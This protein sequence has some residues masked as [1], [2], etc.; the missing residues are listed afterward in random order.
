MRF[1]SL[2]PQWERRVED[3]VSKVVF[4]RLGPHLAIAHKSAVELLSATS[5]ATIATLPLKHT[6]ALS[7]SYDIRVLMVGHRDGG[8]S[9]NGLI[10]VF[11]MAELKNMG[12]EHELLLSQDSI[13]HHLDQG[14]R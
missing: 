3:S 13:P 8:K 9:G 11:S 10:S 6:Y 4:S 14:D 1:P 7:I 5:G 12:K 2:S